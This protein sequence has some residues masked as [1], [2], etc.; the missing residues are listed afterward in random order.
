MREPISRDARLALDLALTIR[1]DG[2]GGVADDLTDEAGLTA[3]VRAHPEALPTSTR[4]RADDL[5]ETPRPSARGRHVVDADDRGAAPHPHA[6]NRH[7]AGFT[8][9]AEQLAAVRTPPAA[10]PAR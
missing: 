6:G 1:H 5:G 8:A 10:R 4:S 9:D 2:N 3:W 7:A